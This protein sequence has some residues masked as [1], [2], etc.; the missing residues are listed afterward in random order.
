MEFRL[1]TEQLETKILLFGQNKRENK[2]SSNDDDETTQFIPI[3]SDDD[4][5]ISIEHFR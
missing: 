1:M 4:L 3:P 5:Y 2:S